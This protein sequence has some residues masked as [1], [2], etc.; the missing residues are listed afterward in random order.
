MKFLFTAVILFTMSRFGYAQNVKSTPCTN[1]CSAFSVT[2]VKGGSCGDHSLNFTVTNNTAGPKS[3]RMYS[4]M[5]DGKW[6]DN[7]WGPNNFAPGSSTTFSVCNSTGKY[8]IYFG[9]PDYK[10]RDFPSLAMIQEI[11]GKSSSLYG[12][13]I[14]Q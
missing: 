9:E 5:T 8:V 2:I 4:E 10:I 12:R 13:D 14:K 1:R 11:Y 6:N 3:I 7:G